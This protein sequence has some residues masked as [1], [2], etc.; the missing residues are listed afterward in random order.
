M[1]LT[2]QAYDGQAVHNNMIDALVAQELRR[3]QAAQAETNARRAEARSREMRELRMRLAMSRARNERISAQLIEKTGR[4]YRPPEKRPVRDALLVA[5]AYAILA[6][7][8][9]ARAGRTAAEI[10]RDVAERMRHEKNRRA[11]AR[12]KRQKRRRE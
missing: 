8:A 9:L 11:R 5:Y 3:R 4:A 6:A 7:A 1:E 2:I 10:G 12:R